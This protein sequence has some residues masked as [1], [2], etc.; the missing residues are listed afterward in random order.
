MWKNNVNH[1]H[2]QNNDLQLALTNSNSILKSSIIEQIGWELT[3]GG[4][5]TI[6]H[7]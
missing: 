6:L 7:L 5:H 4:V 1:V 3:E 2:A